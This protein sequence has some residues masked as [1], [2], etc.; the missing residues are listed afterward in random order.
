MEKLTANGL[1]AR[2]PYTFGTEIEYLQKIGGELVP[3]SV[4]V[5]LG[6][7]PAV[8]ALALL[9]GAADTPFDFYAVDNQNFTGASHLIGAG[10]NDR[11]YFIQD[12][13]W[14][15]AERFS[16]KSVDLLIVDACHDYDC[17]VKDIQAWW[18]RVKVGGTVF[19]HD[20][21]EPNGTLSAGV[22]PAVEK[23]RNE[24]WEELDRPGISIVFKRI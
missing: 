14:N 2:L 19:F 9:E 18:G 16:F 21:L 3:G 22:Y 6:V 20:Y 7:G 15:A 5:M 10:F 17:V 23:F 24:S 4:V 8:M 12:L 1:N 13:S 11:V